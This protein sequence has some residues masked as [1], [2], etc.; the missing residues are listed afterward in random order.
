[1]GAVSQL[2]AETISRPALAMLRKA[3]VDVSCKNIVSF[4]QNAKRD[5][6]CPMESACKNAGTPEQCVK[7]IAEK[8]AAI[9]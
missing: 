2:Y 8:F 6:M 4:I 3:R 7:I 5:G 1:M 9:K